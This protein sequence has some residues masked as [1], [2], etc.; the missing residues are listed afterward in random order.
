M[1]DPRF[2]VLGLPLWPGTTGPR[3][4]VRA[5]GNLAGILTFYGDG[6]PRAPA[7]VIFEQRSDPPPSGRVPAPVTN[8]LLKGGRP[9]HLEEISREET[10]ATVL[11]T[12]HLCARVRWSDPRIADVRFTWHRFHLCIASWEYQLD[13]EFFASVGVLPTPRHPSSR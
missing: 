1:T 11:G 5:D 2:P 3:V 9:E 7:T 12:P 13:T 4:A 6:G 8:L 10:T